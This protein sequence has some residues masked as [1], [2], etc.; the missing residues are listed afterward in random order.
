MNSRPDTGRSRHTTTR[1][2]IAEV[3][4]TCLRLQTADA[5]EPSIYDFAKIGLLCVSTESYVDDSGARWLVRCSFIR[6]HERGI[7]NVNCG[8]Y[9]RAADAG[10]LAREILFAGARARAAKEESQ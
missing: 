4:G 2:T 5:N 3:E 9:A 8:R 6:E 10:A 1:G 7:R